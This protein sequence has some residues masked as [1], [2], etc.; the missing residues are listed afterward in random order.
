VAPRSRP[1]EAERVLE[2]ARRLRHDLGKYVRF[3][4]PPQRETDAEMLRERLRSDVLSTRSGP[5]GVCGAVE[6]FE[7]WRREHPSLPR[8]G[9]F[10]ERLGRITRAVSVIGELAPA[11]DRL[12]REELERLDLAT[13]EIARECRALCEEAPPARKVRR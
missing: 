3:S 6:V 9:R 5:D 13:L 8:S 1:S 4:A 10:G 12:S 11:L 7:S 2:A